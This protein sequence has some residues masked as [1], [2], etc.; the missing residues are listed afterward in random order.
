MNP[1]QPTPIA[2]AILYHPQG[3]LLQLRDDV[4]G[5]LYPGQWGFFGGHLE[6][7]E[8]PIEGLARELEE[9][10]GYHPQGNVELFR[11]YGDDRALRYVFYTPLT[12]PVSQLV[13]GEGWDLKIVSWPEIEA[14]E[15]FSAIAQ[16]TR[17]LGKLHQ[18]ILL[19][20]RSTYPTLISPE[21]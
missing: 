16:Q 2:V 10:I 11:T 21:P 7:G 8:T 12:V 19:D 6:P 4:P 17:P 15:A 13:L 1:R 3:C 18:Q 20:F 9:E 5:I 14:G